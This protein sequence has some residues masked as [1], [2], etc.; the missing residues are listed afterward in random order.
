MFDIV[1][2][3][4]LFIDDQVTLISNESK[5]VEPLVVLQGGCCRTWNS[6]HPCEVH[7]QLQLWQQM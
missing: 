4:D 2:K 1:H 6:T 5:L 3:D 7:A